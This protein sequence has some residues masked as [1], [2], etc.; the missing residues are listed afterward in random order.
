ML[1]MGF[2]IATRTA[3]AL[4]RL[5]DSWEHI[6]A[7]RP[8]SKLVLSHGALSLSHDRLGDAKVCP[9]P[10]AVSAIHRQCLVLV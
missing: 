7:V 6:D 4:R 9:F 2:E 1:F 3:F 10:N 8:S 5:V